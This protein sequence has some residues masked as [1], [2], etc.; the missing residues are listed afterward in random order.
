MAKQGATLIATRNQPAIGSGNVGMNS[1]SRCSANPNWL[2]EETKR[3]APIIP[4]SNVD[5][6]RRTLVN[7]DKEGFNGSVPVPKPN[8]LFSGR[9]SFHQGVLVA[10]P[11]ND[12][13]D[14]S[15]SRDAAMAADVRLRQKEIAS[16]LRDSSEISMKPSKSS[17]Q[18]GQQGK[19]KANSQLHVPEPSFQEQL[20]VD[21][22][23]VM[24]ARSRFANEI[25]AE[26]YVKSRR[27]VSELE[28]REEK[29]ETKAKKNQAK[30]KKG[31]LESAIVKEWYCPI[32]EHTTSF[33]PQAC[34]R[35]G[36]KVKFDRSVKTKESVEEKRLELTKKAV[37][38]GGLILG[39]GLEWSN[40]WSRF[41]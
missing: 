40:R 7:T 32:C 14:Q 18:V 19:N 41:S 26:E 37:A 8:K 21:F 30:S 11:G 9:R 34:I 3:R 28:Q 31:E 27:V 10:M 13:A 38:D 16:T 17:Q 29:A 6:K 39:A 25:D 33:L 23:K 1:S 36:H 24:S 22:D 35:S 4:A 15:V 5:K 20:D 12:S 2:S